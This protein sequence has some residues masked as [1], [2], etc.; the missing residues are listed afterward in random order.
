MAISIAACQSPDSPV[1]VEGSSSGALPSSAS[2]GGT[3][4]SEPVADSSSGAVDSTSGSTTDSPEP[5]LPPD[6]GSGKVPPPPMPNFVEVTEAAGLDL[7]PGEIMPPPFCVLDNISSHPDDL[8][9][10]CLPERALGAAAIGDFDGDGW[11]DIFLTRVQGPD[12]LLHNQGDGTFVDVAEARGL[13]R[14]HV[15]GGAAWVDI[16]GDG[17]LDLM[18]TALGDTRHYLYVNDGAGFFSEE[19]V[20]RGVALE[21]GFIRVGTSVAVGDYDLDGFVDLFVGDWRSTIALDGDV[22]Y[23]RLLRNRGLL[24]PGTFEDVTEQVGIDMRSVS[25]QVGA[26]PGAWGFAPA[27]V[28]LDGDRYPELTLVADFGASRLWWNDGAGGFVDRTLAAGIGTEGNGM[29]STFGDYDD[30]GDLDWFVSAI[31]SPSLEDPGNRMFRN[32][33]GLVFSDVTDE[34]DVRDGGWGWGA[35]MFDFD[36][37]GDLDLALASGFPA[38]VYANDPVRLWFNTGAGP[39]PELAVEQ[40]VDYQ[41]QGRGLVA[42]D[43]DRDGD[44]DL[45]VHSNTESPGLF[46]NDQQGGSWLEVTTTGGFGNSQGIGVEVRVQE[47]AGGPV[48]LRTIGVGSHYSGQAEAAAYFG[49]EDGDAPLHR[50]ELTWPLTGTVLEFEEVPRNQHLRLG[51]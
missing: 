38:T 42:F 4:V 33:G 17:D 48:Q 12:W 29:G 28:D 6:L 40:G 35:S 51:S 39:W 41:R 45:L 21:S 8:G 5:P 26:P 19:G 37:D 27:F 24:G 25:A 3:T 9:D 2:E 36:L 16:E 23:N 47:T 22:D 11:P 32:E 49:F 10:Y 31:M 13:S 50:V 18:L 14:P 20:E 1:S 43:Y 15:T 46:R 44:L 34:L 7:D 30:D